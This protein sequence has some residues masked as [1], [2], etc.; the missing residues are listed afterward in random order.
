MGGF[1]AAGPPLAAAI[2]GLK[3]QVVFSAAL[4]ALHAQLHLPYFWSLVSF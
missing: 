3:V 1:G 4:H 2:H